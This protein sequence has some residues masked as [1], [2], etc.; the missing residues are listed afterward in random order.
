MKAFGLFFLPNLAFSLTLPRHGPG[1]S[2]FQNSSRSNVTLAQSYVA[3]TTN[4]TCTANCTSTLTTS[5]SP[6]ATLA[7]S[8]DL[9][10]SLSPNDSL[11]FDDSLTSG[12]TAGSSQLGSTTTGTQDVAV[13]EYTFPSSRLGPVATLAPTL[14]DTHEASDPTHLVPQPAASGAPMYYIQPTSLSKYIML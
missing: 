1:A 14:P 5:S 12:Q 3:N 7:S 4:A 11:D 6:V 2:H 13:P 9:D 10:G 8:V